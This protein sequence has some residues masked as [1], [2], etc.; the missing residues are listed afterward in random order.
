MQWTEVL[1]AVRVVEVAGR[2]DI[3]VR[4]VQYDARWDYRWKSV[5]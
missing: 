1:E 5:Y 4:G 3:E 2:R